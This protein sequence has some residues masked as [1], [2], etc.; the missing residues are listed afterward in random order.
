MSR[1]QELLSLYIHVIFK[2][3]MG[4]SY[5][6]FGGMVIIHVV[7]V[8][9][10]LNK[11]QGHKRGVRLLY[12]VVILCL[13]HAK[14]FLCSWTLLSFFIVTNHSIELFFVSFINC[15]I[16]CFIQLSEVHLSLSTREYHISPCIAI[17][18]MKM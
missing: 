15:S 1:N 7:I 12:I 13:Y 16:Q 8:L 17:N 18:H 10:L 9:Y 5:T 11:I 6:W 4:L 3:Q 14:H 2:K